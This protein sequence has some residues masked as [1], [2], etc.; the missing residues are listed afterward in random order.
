MIG[1]CEYEIVIFSLIEFLYEENMI[2]YDFYDSF[3]YLV[4]ILYHSDRFIHI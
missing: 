4:I 3:I 2:I 1:F